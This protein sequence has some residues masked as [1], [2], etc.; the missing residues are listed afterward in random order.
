MCA[1]WYQLEH[2]PG[3]AQMAYTGPNQT[4]AFR[5]SDAKNYKQQLQ[6]LAMW[7]QGN[8]GNCLVP[9]I[10]ILPIQVY[11]VPFTK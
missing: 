11:N 10:N 1:L 7:R 5:C 8:F 4:L 9:N 2:K 3:T 6:T